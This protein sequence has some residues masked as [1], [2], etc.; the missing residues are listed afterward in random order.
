MSLS[1]VWRQ[2]GRTGGAEIGCGGAELAGGA[3]WAGGGDPAGGG[4][5]AG[6]AEVA[7]GADK[8]GAELDG[9]GCSGELG[10]EADS[11]AELDGMG[12]SGE[13]GLVAL[14][15]R[16][17][18]VVVPEATRVVA[19]VYGTVTSDVFSSHLWQTT[20]VLVT[21]I[22]DTVGTTSTEVVLPAV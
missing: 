12:C 10:L 8:A 3:D 19:I 17:A 5:P 18:A 6:G 22:V 15:V 13:L 2:L 1:Q 4:E 14:W 16:T 21:L 7:G 9:T 11:G 20:W